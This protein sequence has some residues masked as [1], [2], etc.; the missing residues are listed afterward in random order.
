MTRDEKVLRA[1]ELRAQ[2]LTAPAIGELLDVN[3]S[4][5]RNWY[6]GS[7]CRCGKPLDGSRGASSSTECWDCRAEPARER[8]RKLIA[9]WNEG[10][11][12][13]AIGEEFDLDPLV[14]NTIAQNRRFEGWDVARRHLPNS[15]APERYAQIAAWVRDGLTNREIAERL[16]TSKESVGQMTTHAR[17]AGY[18]MPL[19]VEVA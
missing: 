7:T 14:V 2:G 11:S 9:M 18:E 17:R 3:E 6:C 10:V 12:A 19:R 16:G 1:R 4:T 15:K 8:D 13:A 5:V